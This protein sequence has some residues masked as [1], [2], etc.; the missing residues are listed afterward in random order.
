MSRAF[1]EHG[2]LIRFLALD[3]QSIVGDSC[4]VDAGCGMDASGCLSC[5]L[6]TFSSPE[7]G[8]HW[9]G[10]NPAALTLWL[11]SWVWTFLI[12]S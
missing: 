11:G 7:L 8:K 2:G 3:L 6:I 5:G 12:F 9:T 1:K 10:V 4:G